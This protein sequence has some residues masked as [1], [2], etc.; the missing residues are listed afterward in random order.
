MSTGQ[1]TAFARADTARD[2]LRDAIKDRLGAERHVKLA[3][4][5][6]ERGRQL[7]AAAKAKLA[8]FGDVD[9]LIL[10]HRTKQIKDLREAARRPI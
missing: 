2:K 6:E 9:G 1:Q 4:E 7:L 10:G 3:Q 8:G 5:A